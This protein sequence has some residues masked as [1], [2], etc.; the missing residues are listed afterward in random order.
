MLAL[1]SGSTL[2]ASEAVQIS[3]KFCKPDV[4]RQP[5]GVFSLYV[6]CDDALGTNVAVYLHKLGAP[7]S[8]K[9]DLG[10][11]F[12]QGEKWSYDVTSYSWIGMN[13][14]LLTTS[15]IYGSGSVY[16]LELETQTHKEVLK[17]EPEACLTYLDS[18]KDR[19]ANVVI[20]YCESQ[21]EKVV[22]ISL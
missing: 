15:A 8:G 9:Y 12:W 20:T 19:K 17:L 3:P 13:E 21:E 14:L 18:V 4:H 22:E 1:I 6:F 7:L 16:L 5:E 11:R 2:L 10:T